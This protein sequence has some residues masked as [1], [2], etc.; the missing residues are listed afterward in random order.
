MAL[1]KNTQEEVDVACESC[2]QV[3]NAL[4]TVSKIRESSEVKGLL[5]PLPIE[6]PQ[7]LQNQLF[8]VILLNG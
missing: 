6:E 2:C 3:P 7:L 1:E 8:P 4:N 5:V